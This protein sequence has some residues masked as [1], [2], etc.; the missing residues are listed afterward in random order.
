MDRKTPRRAGSRVQE[1]MCE[2]DTG[3][4]RAEASAMGKSGRGERGVSRLRTVHK[5]VA[6]RIPS[7]MRLPKDLHHF[8]FLLSILPINSTSSCF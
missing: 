8:Y 2:G 6:S 1:Q 5:T 4:P 7:S 3:N